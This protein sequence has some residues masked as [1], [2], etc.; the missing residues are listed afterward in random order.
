MML[1]PEK[2]RKVQEELD[3]VIGHGRLPH[4]SDRPSLPY[5]DAAWKESARWHPTTPQ[6]MQIACSFG[7]CL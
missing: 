3:H 4:A 5:C 6:G 2:Q 1:H 7:L